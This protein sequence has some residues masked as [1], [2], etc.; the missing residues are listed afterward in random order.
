VVKLPI[1]DRVGDRKVIEG[2]ARQARLAGALAHPGIQRLLGTSLDMGATRADR[3]DH[4]DGSDGVDGVDGG[5][6][7]AHL[8]FEYAEGPT[9]TSSLDDEG[10]MHPGDVARLGM[11]LAGVLHYLHHGAGIAHLD[12]KP[13]NICLVDGRPV[14]LDFDAACQVGR[15]RHPDAPIGSPPYMAPE[16]FRDDEVTPRSDL[17]ALGAVLYEAATGQCPYHPE[18]TPDGW[19]VP[20]E[21]GAPP[22]SGAARLPG[23]LAEVIDRLLEPR[24]DRRPAWS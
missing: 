18:E 10:P 11:Q 5:D 4:V 6:G 16:Q 13:S 3:A 20:Q 2:L 22:V 9:L 15:R 7:A 8:V 12:V 23:P 1:P 14:L 21:R 24:P 19:T 17:F